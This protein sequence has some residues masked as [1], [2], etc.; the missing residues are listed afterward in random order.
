MSTP[1]TGKQLVFNKINATNP[2]LPETLSD[3]NVTLGTPV[4]NTDGGVTKNTAIVVTA[5][6]GSIYSGS[7]T[8]YYDRVNLSDIVGAGPVGGNTYVL[9]NQTKISDVLAPFNA[10]YNT[11]IQLEDIADGA[12]PAPSAVDG[13][14]EFALAALSTSHAFQ[15]SVNLIFKPNDV[16]LADVVTVT[17][18]GLLDTAIVQG[19]DSTTA[20]YDAINQSNPSLPRPLTLTNAALSGVAA[21]DGTD[22]A[23]NGLN[24]KIVVTPNA[25]YGYTTDPITVYY[26]RL[27]LG[28]ITGA[29]GISVSWD[30]SITSSTDLLASYN[31]AT[32]AS[33]SASDIVVEALPTNP[34]DGSTVNYTLTAAPG[35]LAF[36]GSVSIALVSVVVVPLSFSGAL[37]P[38]ATV[39]TAYSSSLTIVGGTPPYTNPR[40]TGGDSTN[41]LPA[42]LNLS[43]NGNQLTLAGSPTAAGYSGLV[44]AVDDSAGGTATSSVQSVT[45]DNN[46][47]AQFG[48]TYPSTT[49]NLNLN[50]MEAIRKDTT[51]NWSIIHL[52][53]GVNGKVYFELNLTSYKSPQALYV[54]FDR[55]ADGVAT[56]PGGSQGGLGYEV[57]GGRLWINNVATTLGVV[58]GSGDTVGFAID[59]TNRYSVKIWISRNGAWIGGGNPA[60]GTNPTATM[61]WG[62]LVYQPSIATSHGTISGSAAQAVTAHT[63]PASLVYAAPSGFA[64]GLISS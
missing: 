52:K 31:Q 51:S 63:T 39:G 54:G 12:L 44:I 53:A 38:A 22:T 55:Q 56:T 28:A 57:G 20:V 7:V 25:G 26:N 32:G 24:T 50:N 45:V 19:T 29:S 62:G 34:N 3:S 42:G 41:V 11:N 16:A 30:G 27:D 21:T 35:S 4:V 2:T 58:F 5:L 10:L 60:T 18:T 48:P 14:I 23:A 37:T 13:A 36:I 15:G 49:Y 47:F 40:L 43:I 64:A 9:S 8:A 46:V 59:A 6:D 17:L 33:L 61:A 1:V